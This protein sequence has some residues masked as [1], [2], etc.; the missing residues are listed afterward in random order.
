VAWPP[1]TPPIDRLLFRAIAEGESV[2]PAPAAFHYQAS[3][4][5]IMDMGCAIAIDPS[6]DRVR[7]AWTAV[8]DGVRA[9]AARSRY[10]QNMVLHARFIGHSDALLSPA[11]GN[12]A[13]CCIEILTYWR[14]RDYEPY[15][16]EVYGEWL[17]LGGRP[18]WGKLLWDMPAIR[19]VYGQRI[20]AFNQIRCRL[21]P[22]GMFLNDCLA[23]LFAVS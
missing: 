11:A 23:D 13:T 12:E 3:Y 15:F 22:G 8:T 16:Q 10:P 6:F 9:Y 5:K 14:T 7:E 2:V 17:A 21:D 1:V 19:R 18:H 4:I 20:N